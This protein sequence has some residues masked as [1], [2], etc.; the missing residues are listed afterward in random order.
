MFESRESRLMRAA[1]A[2][3]AEDAPVSMASRCA[4][5]GKDMQASD[6]SGDPE[7]CADCAGKEEAD[8]PGGG[9]TA[10]LTRN[11]APRRSDDGSGQ[12]PLDVIQD[13]KLA[14]GARK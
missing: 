13:R 14:R 5:C 2:E 12:A 11:P 7:R 3:L 1:L 4:L 8:R 10:P 9:L 6:A